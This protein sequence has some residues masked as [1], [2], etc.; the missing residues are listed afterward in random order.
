MHA[1]QNNPEFER[2]ISILSEGE[3][4]MATAILNSKVVGPTEWLAARK[5]LLKKEKEFTRLRDDLSRQRRELPWEKVEKDYIFEGPTGKVAL[6]ELFNGRSQLI[7]YHFMFGPG[8]KEGCPSCSFIADNFDGMRTHLEQRDVAFTAISRATLPEIEAFKNRMGW[9]FPWVSSN[10]TDFNYDYKV[11]FTKADMQPGKHPYNFGTMDFPSDEGPGLSV[12][13]KDADGQIYHTYSTYTRGLDI[14]LTTY[15]YLDMTPKGRD[16]AEM[17]P[18]AMAWVRHHDK[19]ENSSEAASCCSGEAAKSRKMLEPV[20]AE[21][22]QEVA[23]T[24]R[25]LERVPAD[26]LT[27]KPHD[28]SMTLG[29]LA[30]HI[31]AIPDRISA[32]AQT[33]GFDVSQANF[34]PPQP[35]DLDEVLATFET[36]VVE[37]EKRLRSMTDESAMQPWTMTRADTVVFT[38]PRAGIVRTIMLNHWYHHRG[39]LCVYLRL[40]EVPVPVVYGRSADE[41]PFR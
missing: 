32:L 10:A 22:Q 29:Q 8:W 4:T 20:I 26:K 28:K 39:Q 19:Y 7:V 41:N 30:G 13:Y 38:V 40:L 12:F 9:K 15:N 18:H 25:I 36:G 5:E 27:W 3:T 1:L 23:T 35:K 33:N 31:A 37:G 14:L 21:F 2:I 34:V 16:E 11:S 24:R 6:T 17:T